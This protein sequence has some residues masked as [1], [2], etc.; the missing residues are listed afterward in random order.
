MS[1][2]IELEPDG[3]TLRIRFPYRA[4]LVDEVK[5]FPGRRWNPGEK[6]WQVPS[7]QVEAVVQT[8][9]RHGFQLAPEVSGLMA[10]TLPAPA[11]PV[12]PAVQAGGNANGDG[13]A[14]AAAVDALTVSALNARVAA[15]VQQ[16]FPASVWVIGEVYDFDKN[17]GRANLFFKLIEKGNGE[18]VIAAQVSVVLWQG[19]ARHLLARLQ[20]GAEPL[21]LRD[22]LEIRVKGRVE[23][24]AS[25][26]E[27][28]MVI[29]DI[30]PAFTLGKLALQ[31]ERILA[32][33]RARGLQERNRLL[34]LPVP[35]LRVAVLTSPDSDGWNDF[36]KEL[37]A[38]GIG[39]QVTLYPIK[40]QGETLRPTMLA[41]LRWFAT[42][43]AEH[44]VLCVVRGGGSRSDLAWFDDLD[45]ALAVAQHPLKVV[46]GIGHQRDQSVLDLIAHSEKTPTAV[47]A[48]LVRAVRDAEEAVHEAARRLHDASL[49][50]LRNAR[51]ALTRLAHDLRLHLAAVLAEQRERLRAVPFQLARGL[52]QYCARRR[53]VLARVQERVIAAVR[54]RLEREAAALAQHEIRQ[55]ALDPRQ[56]LRRGYVI[57]RRAGTIVTDARRLAS[58]EAIALSF[59]DGRVL[60]RVEEVHPEPET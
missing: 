51:G 31:R 15:A 12:A 14:A 46:C 54:R 55:Q 5:R 34:P 22:G 7:G 8:F 35:P 36:L 4:D 1:G 17:K 16:A 56:V 49:A 59:R 20:E 60:G 47:G 52:G 3:R 6:Y 44:D 45:L 26:G 30:D 24:A 37:E 27:Y 13:G 38:S 58:G 10:G 50:V 29:E 48:H 39:F 40:V 33:L 23:L 28:R 2:S 53:E 9:L 32:E 42:H 43:A 18:G 57:V 11:K 19:M 41:G 21:T 25:R